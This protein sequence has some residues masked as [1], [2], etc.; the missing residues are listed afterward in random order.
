MQIVERIEALDPDRL[1]GK[2]WERKAMDGM[3]ARVFAEAAPLEAA[4]S[5]RQ[6]PEVVAQ[7]SSDSDDGDAAA[8]TQKIRK[9]KQG[10]L[11][12]RL[13]KPFPSHYVIV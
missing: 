13:W 1:C 9:R 8:T 11:S 3:A 5:G 10:V 4:S 6:D 12:A 2:Y 7:Q